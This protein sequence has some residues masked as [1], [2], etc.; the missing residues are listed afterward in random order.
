MQARGPLQDRLMLW[1]AQP[2]LHGGAVSCPTPVLPPGLVT[3]TRGGIRGPG[4]SPGAEGLGAGT[5]GQLRSPQEDSSLHSSSHPRLASPRGQPGL[6]REGRGRAVPG[7][8]P[9]GR[10][11]R[12]PAWALPAW[13]RLAPRLETARSPPLAFS[14]SPPLALAV[15]QGESE[16]L[17]P[18]AEQDACPDPTGV[19][20]ADH[21]SPQDAP[22]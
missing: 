6:R 12:G 8:S 7:P 22:T 3:P 19:T 20:W 2:Q 9:G 15:I 5:P 18:G 4:F 1:G 13:T 11:G 21:P 16:E 17:G 14:T 10:R